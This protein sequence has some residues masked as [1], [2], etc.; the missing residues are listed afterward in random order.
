MNLNFFKNLNK[1][2]IN[3][4]TE[5][6]LV[7]IKNDTAAIAT[8]TAT[9]A[10]DTASIATNSAAVHTHT[11]NILPTKM[12]NMANSMPVAIA[13]NQTVPVFGTMKFD[14][15][16]VLAANAADPLFYLRKIAKQ[17][18]SR[19]TMDA[20]KRQKIYVDG[21]SGINITSST[22]LSSLAGYDQKMFQYSARNLF[23]VNI[24]TR[25]HFS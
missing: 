19:A 24:R 8:K 17:L 5:E 15:S 16:T 25:L 13:S 4:A 10:A 7:N 12:A 9:L 14:T 18:E 6:T 1:Q 2:K 23:A 20:S 22:P 21:T 11:V 3:P